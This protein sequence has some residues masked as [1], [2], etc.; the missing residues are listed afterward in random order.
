MRKSKIN[1]YGELTEPG[2]IRLGRKSDCGGKS[3]RARE[4]RLG[5]KSD[6]GGKSDRARGV[7]TG[8]GKT[9]REP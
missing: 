5:R 7:R 2:D 3:D 4:V 9:N 8:R 1:R 6:C